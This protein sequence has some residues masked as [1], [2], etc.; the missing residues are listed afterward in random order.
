MP[1]FEIDGKIYPLD[2]FKLELPALD[3]ISWLSRQRLYPKVFWKEEGILRAA[4][5]NLLSF[6]HA[7]V[8][9]AFNAIDVRLYGGMRFTQNRHNDE[10][11]RGFPQTCFWLPQIE[12]SQEKGKT[13]VIIH[14]LNEKASPADAGLFDFADT[15]LKAAAMPSLIDRQET[16]DFVHWQ[17]Y[18]GH[19][20]E[21]MASGRMDKLVLARKSSL[22]FSSPLSVWPLLFHL[23]ESAKQ[24]AVFA[25]QLSF[26][27][28]FLGATPERLF[29][30]EG[31]LLKTDALAGTSLRGKTP[32]ED[33][34]LE[35]K[36]LNQPK[37]YREFKCVA[38]FLEKSLRPLSQEMEWEW[39]KMRVLK[40]SHV[41]HIHNRLSIQL[42]PEI[43]DAELIRTLHPTPA[44][45]GLPRDNALS[46]LKNIE[47][48][49]RGWYGAPIGYVS[50]KGA[51]LYVG[52]RS[53]LIRER[54]L[55]LFAGTGLVKGSHAESE[56]EEL[57]QKIRP[58]TELFL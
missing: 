34:Q 48:F 12:V 47:P 4:V 2:Q 13:E 58:F 42:K 21:E 49:D 25:F 23:N 27:L 6:S 11:W 22:H 30:R 32:E 19:A 3:L 16:P 40:T 55:H 44:L 56:W 7:P 29:Q 26:N 33:Q 8:I 5:G 1:P 39:P 52:I 17:K 28:C 57:E 10:T 14:Y 36:L 53:G 50:P 45:G 38:E 24:A 20:L 9:S 35:D 31:N 51:N 54:S 46:F 43:S 41:Q 15:P 18:V 37:E